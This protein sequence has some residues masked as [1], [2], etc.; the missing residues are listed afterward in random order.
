MKVEVGNIPLPTTILQK[1]GEDMAER[2]QD[3]SFA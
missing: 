3:H 2:Q 1:A